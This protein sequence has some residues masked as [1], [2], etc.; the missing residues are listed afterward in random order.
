MGSHENGATADSA[1]ARSG[2]SGD[3]LHTWVAAP[4]WAE[5]H[6]MPPAPFV[7]DDLVL[8][9]TTLRQT[10]RTCLGGRRLRLRLS[11]AFGGAP[12]PVTAVSVA[13]P[14]GGRAGVAAIEPGSARPVTFHGRPA[15][16]VPVGAQMVSDPLDFDVPAHANLTVTVYLAEGQASAEVTAHPGSRTT[17][18]LRAGNHLAAADLPDATAVDFWYFLSGLEVPAPAEPESA[19]AVMFGDSLTDGRGSTT[20]A[21]NRW[22]DLFV[23]RLH[24]RPRTRAVAVLNQAI[25]GNRVLADGVG[26][27]A[28]ARLE[29]DVLAVSGVRWLVVFAGT[30][31]IGTAEATAAAQKQIADDL[32]AAY[33]QIVLR[34]HAHGITVYGATLLPFG[35]HAAYDDPAGHREAARQTVNRWI[36]T[37][38][39]FDHVIDFDRA[40]RDPAQPRRLRDGY[41]VGDHLHLNPAGYQALADAVPVALFQP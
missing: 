1:P 41:D 15:V 40:A 19:A 38:G 22:P 13:L 24:R 35:G 17:S 28:L 10:V 31:D 7:R 11:N 37:G 23:S 14:R 16:V 39:R 4:R 29:R 21:N 20:N 25:G 8:A 33:H 27:S 5:P 9:D 2:R 6:E 34:A 3:W 36:R 30:N 26:P 12:L 32:I 18:Y